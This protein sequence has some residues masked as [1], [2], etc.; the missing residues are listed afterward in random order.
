MLKFIEKFDS[1][2]TVRKK[3]FIALGAVI[4]AALLTVAGFAYPMEVFSLLVDSTAGSYVALTLI[5]VILSCIFG[6]LFSILTRQN[7]SALLTFI[8]NA[9]FQIG[10]FFLFA[11]FRY[12]M[13]Y[14]WIITV[15][16][17]TLV[18]VLL[19]LISKPTP[20]SN[21]K[22]TKEKSPVST[23]VKVITAVIYALAA[24]ALY[25]TLAVVWL[26]LLINS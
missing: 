5:S 20:P 6:W 10:M 24:D 25:I 4:I 9:V 18:T 1:K 16:V 14:L 15:I 12:S 22:R 26:K 7:I 8:S 11:A 19:F 23:K 21:I 17:H 3:S 13:P 2:F